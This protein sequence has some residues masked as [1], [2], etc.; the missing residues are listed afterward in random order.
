MPTALIYQCINGERRRDCDY[1]PN[2]SSQGGECCFGL[3]HEYGDPDCSACAI[4]IDCSQITH[5]VTNADPRLSRRIIYPNTPAAKVPV[6]TVPSYS[7][8][9]SQTQPLTG[10]SQTPTSLLMQSTNSSD[11]IKLN[12]DHSLIH[13]FAVIGFW[14]ALE[15]FFTLILDFLRKKRPQ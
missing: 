10:R 15:G 12:P 1:C 11:P 5:R 6:R 13:Q 3:R 8:P 4:H 2:H 14:G 9:L 7:N